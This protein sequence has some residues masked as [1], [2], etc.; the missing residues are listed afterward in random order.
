MLSFPDFE[1]A[2]AH[3]GLVAVDSTVSSPVLCRPLE[4]GADLVVHSATKYLGGH[5]D[6][7]MGAV[8]CR[9]EEDR[10]RL[11]AVRSRTGMAA[12][13]DAVWLLLRSLGTLELRVLRQSETALELARRLGEH[14]QVERVRYPGLGDERAARYMSGGFGGLLSFDLR[15]GEEAA[16]RVETT[17][18]V[19]VNAT[20][21]G[22]IHSS[23][24]SRHRWEG[25]R[26]PQGL[27]R[28]SV[29][30]EDVDVLWDDLEQAL[31]SV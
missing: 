6:I 28:L 20:S 17:T 24:E 29:G 19:I 12:G 31:A 2:A 15:D 10:G 9:R 18:R 27:L 21:L 5:S 4:H 8:V 14:P 25:D 11:A 3:P 30:L 26:V 23:M 13:P 16:R 7:L 1:A 22:G